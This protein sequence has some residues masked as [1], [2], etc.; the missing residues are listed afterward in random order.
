MRILELVLD[1]KEP[2]PGRPRQKHDRQ[3]NQHEEPSPT[4]QI[5]R[6]ARSPIARLVAMVETQG[7]APEPIRWAGAA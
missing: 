3:V 7:S 2:D 5:I 1:V 6:A 4:V